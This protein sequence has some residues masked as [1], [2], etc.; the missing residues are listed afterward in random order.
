MNIIAPNIAKTFQLFL[1]LHA[2][3]H[4]IHPYSVKDCKTNRIDMDRAEEW[5]KAEIPIGDFDYCYDVFQP[6]MGMPSWEITW[7]VVRYWKEL[8]GEMRIPSIYMEAATIPH[9]CG[10]KSRISAYASARAPSHIALAL[11][12]AEMRLF[13]PHPWG[14]VAASM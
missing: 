1:S 5:R 14:I 8:N 10:G 9:G 12:Y 11:A 4:Y 3:C 13:P 2:F 6:S 7:D